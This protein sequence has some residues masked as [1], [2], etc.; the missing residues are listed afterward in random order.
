MHDW[1]AYSVCNFTNLEKRRGRLKETVPDDFFFIIHF[2]AIMHRTTIVQ[3]KIITIICSCHFF[4]PANIYRPSLGK[5]RL[6]RPNQKLIQPPNFYLRRKKITILLRIV[7]TT[8]V[9]WPIF[10]Y[11]KKK[12]FKNVTKKT[13]KL[14]TIHY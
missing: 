3:N 13:S 6:G 14:W 2:Y 1:Q 12:T 9:Q 5:V 7:C 8:T 11:L 10:I 4:C